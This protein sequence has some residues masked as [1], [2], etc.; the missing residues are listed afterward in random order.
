MFVAGIVFS[1]TD[2]RCTRVLPRLD[3]L[4]K[5]S[6]RGHLTVIKLNVAEEAE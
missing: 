4:L 1:R 2:G 5:F 6:R 3:R